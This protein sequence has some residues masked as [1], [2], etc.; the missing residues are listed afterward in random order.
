MWCHFFNLVWFW[1]V[2][3]LDQHGTYP[4]YDGDLSIEGSV[5]L[6]LFD[7]SVMMKYDLKGV[8]SACTTPTNGNNHI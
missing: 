6:N 1:W 7:D 4:E 8:D 5:S 3:S 2:I